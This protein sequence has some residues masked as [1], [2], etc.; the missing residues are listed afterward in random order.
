MSISISPQGATLE[1][2]RL[3]FE[4]P[5]HVEISAAADEAIAAGH[6]VIS[7][8]SRRARSSMG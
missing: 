2:L 4:G 7:D 1:Q 5:I 8:A 6:K 3:P